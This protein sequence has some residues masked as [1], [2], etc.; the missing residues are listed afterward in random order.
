MIPM[1]EMRRPPASRRDQRMRHA[2]HLEEIIT[3]AQQNSR[4]GGE[5][6]TENNPLDDKVCFNQYHRRV[7]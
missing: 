7:W 1:L 5:I 3:V 2:G 4:N 6:E